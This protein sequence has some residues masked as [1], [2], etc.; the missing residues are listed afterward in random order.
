FL[1]LHHCLFGKLGFI[2][3]TAAAAVGTVAFVDAVGGSGSFAFP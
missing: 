1:A 3:G 2:A